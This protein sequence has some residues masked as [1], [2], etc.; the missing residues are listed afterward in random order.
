MLIVRY[1]LDR[2]DLYSGDYQNSH[3][4]LLSGNYTD[5]IKLKTHLAVIFS[6][7]KYNRKKAIKNAQAK[8]KAS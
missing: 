8:E 3:Q 4:E 5:K 2:N 1:T 7:I 6:L